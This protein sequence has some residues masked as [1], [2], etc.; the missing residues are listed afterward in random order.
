MLDVARLAH[1]PEHELQELLADRS[2]NLRA[3]A[4]SASPL[5]SDWRSRRRACASRPCVSLLV[6]NELKRFLTA[7]SALPAGRARFP[8]ALLPTLCWAS[9]NIASSSGVQSDFTTRESR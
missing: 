7:F 8:T 4:A 9:S 3:S 1:A 6:I 5:L 2:P